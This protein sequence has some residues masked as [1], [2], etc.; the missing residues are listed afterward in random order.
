ML[1]LGVLVIASNGA[2]AQDSQDL[3]KQLSNPI[4]SLISVPFQINYDANIGPDRDGEKFV[5]NIQPVVPFSLNEDWNMISRTILPIVGQHDVF[6][7]A[8][9]QFG[10]GDVTQSMFFSPKAT[11]PD[12]IIWGVGPVLVLPTGTNDLLT[13][14]KWG[15]GPTAVVLIQTYG[16]TVGALANHVWSFAGGNDRADVNSTYLQPFVS[17]TTADA[18]TFS[19]NAEASYNWETEDWSVPVNAGVSK[20]VRFGAQPV[21]IGGTVRYWA[22]SPDTGPHG[23]AARLSTTFLFSAN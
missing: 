5:V 13:G 9:D 15:A 20:L 4:A 16:W 17:Y 6:P 21:S 8:G 22:E 2:L 7:E 18:W 11:G 19:L 1:G 14:G 10:L 23:W 12:G 3:A